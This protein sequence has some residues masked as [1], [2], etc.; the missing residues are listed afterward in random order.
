MKKGF[1]LV[2][3]LATLGIIGV[4]AAMTIPAMLHLT[5]KNATIEQ[6]KKASATLNKAVYNSVVVNG[7]IF[8][9]TWRGEDA[10]LKILQNVI[11]PS[12]NV[13]FMC[14]GDV[15]GL[16][17]HCRY[18]VK[19]V[20]GKE[21]DIA[22]DFNS[23]TRFL[24]NDGMLIA[25]TN[26]FA[27][28]EEDDSQTN[29]TPPGDTQ[30]VIGQIDD[31]T[32]GEDPKKLC[33]VFMVDVNGSQKP[34]VVGRDVFFFG[35]YL[36]GSVLPY[37]ANESEEFVNEN[38]SKGSNGRTCAAKLVNGGWEVCYNCKNPYPVWF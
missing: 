18:T 33:G 38:C 22:K 36:S 30:P 29:P 2:E 17:K 37:G 16:S 14:S 10:S 20:D 23:K 1:T 15:E 4:I 28:S 31:C 5:A 25:F 7:N 3:V 11:M 8:S 19:D 9:W 34:N 6:L 27:E 32:F 21:M 24:L 12:L 35:L 26:K 13:G